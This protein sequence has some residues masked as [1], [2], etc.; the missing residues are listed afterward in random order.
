MPI[1]RSTGI[2]VT[3]LGLPWAGPLPGGGSEGTT[4]ALDRA[5]QRY[6]QVL[7]AWLGRRVR[8]E[9]RFNSD[10]RSGGAWV[11]D[12]DGLGSS[13]SP[14]ASSPRTTCSPTGTWARNSR[15]GHLYHHILLK[16]TLLKSG[17]TVP[18]NEWK[19]DETDSIYLPVRGPADGIRLLQRLVDPEQ[20]ARY[21]R[22]TRRHLA[23]GRRT[24]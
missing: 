1:T 5:V 8:I 21:L 12:G 15:A 7:Q 6:A 13:A 17:V 14:P 2:A 11:W 20:L 9:I 23:A 19:W 4:R 16:R 24:R 18:R 10:R 22:S 3:A